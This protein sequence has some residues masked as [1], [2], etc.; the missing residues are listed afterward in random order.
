[1]F[2]VITDN[3]QFFAIISFTQQTVKTKLFFPLIL[4]CIG[5][6][7]V[8]YFSSFTANGLTHLVTGCHL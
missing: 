7:H 6:L 4:V 2:T 8:Y 1:M 5:D 3:Q